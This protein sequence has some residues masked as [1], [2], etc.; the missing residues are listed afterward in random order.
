MR[1]IS[2]AVDG[3]LPMTREKA[4]GPPKASMSSGTV[5]IAAVYRNYVDAVNRIY[6][7]RVDIISVMSGSNDRLRLARERAGFPSA[8]AA[9]IRFHWTVSTYASHE[10]GQ[11]PVPVKAA[12]K[13]ARAFR[14]SAAWILT[15]EGEASNRIVKVVGRVGAGAEVSPEEEQIPPDG[16]AQVELPF[17]IPDD[18]LAFEV[19]GESMWPRYDPGDVVVCWNGQT[20]PDRLIGREAAVKTSKGRRYLK[21]IRAGTRKGTFDLESFNAEPIRNARIEWASE[22]RAVVRALEVRK[23]T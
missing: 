16:L 5:C 3:R 18:A 4:V 9:A 22:V 1:F 21:R 19:Q 8:R 11:T 23:R 15:G 20:D 7:S 12:E 13:Y 17:A 6:V 14:V 2:L 10:N